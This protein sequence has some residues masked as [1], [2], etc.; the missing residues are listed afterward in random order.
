MHLVD[1]IKLPVF[2]YHMTTGD[3]RHRTAHATDQCTACI[4]RTKIQVAVER[5]RNEF[6]T[7]S[8]RNH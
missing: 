3:R 2:F 5:L 1:I 7:K 4:G 6:Q 8:P